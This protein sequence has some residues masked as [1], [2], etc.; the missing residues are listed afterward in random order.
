MAFTLEQ[1]RQKV[2]NLLRDSERNFIAPEMVAGWLNM[3]QT[4]LCL[5][6]KVMTKEATGA[7]IVS[8]LA[9]PTDF[10]API[11][12]TLT[13]GDSTNRVEFTNEDVFDSYQDTGNTPP[14]TLAR[15]FNENI[16]IYPA[17]S[18]GTSYALRYS[19]M[20]ADL[21]DSTDVCVLPMGL[22]LKMV[23]YATAQAKYAEAEIDEAD[24]YISEY[25]REL[26]VPNIGKDKYISS[27]MSIIP[28]RTA[29]EVQ[30][31]QQD[32]YGDW[33]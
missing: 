21:E 2:Y 27:P 32:V 6:T 17:A 15:I 18:A 4:D 26:P 25:E 24:R 13:D 31:I 28:E 1:M 14:R 5:R 9:L 10:V 29:P 16:E 19:Y 20:P 7:T 33:S 23:Q 12:F 22:Q 30:Q 8:T 11:S 3:A